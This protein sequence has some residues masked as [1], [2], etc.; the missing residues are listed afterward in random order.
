VIC[1]DD[2]KSMIRD[3]HPLPEWACFDELR[4]GTGLSFDR[5]IDVAAFNVWPSKGKQR[6]AYEVKVSRSDFLHELAVPQKRE[7]VEKCFQ[8]TFFACTPGV[9]KPEEIPEGWGLLVVTK[10]GDKL[11]KVVVPKYRDILDPDY[12]LWMSI[13]RESCR[14]QNM[15]AERRYNFEGKTLT[16]DEVA[17]IISDRIS[18]HDDRS[19]VSRLRQRLADPFCRLQELAYRRYHIS[20]DE[21]GE[22]TEK[23]IEELLAAAVSERLRGVVGNIHAAH[24]KLGDLLERVNNNEASA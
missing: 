18:I 9:C 5:A 3:R 22:L 10:A 16:A 21:L 17:E 19:E 24:E 1:A 14:E 4:N 23:N 7:W 13:L 15:R 2:I 8:E 20:I 12:W 11:R 6:V